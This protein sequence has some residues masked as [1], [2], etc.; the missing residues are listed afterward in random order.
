MGHGF[1]PVII[2]H[3]SRGEARR[4][5]TPTILVGRCADT[6]MARCEGAM[7]GAAAGSAN[8]TWSVAGLTTVVEGT[9]N[10]EAELRDWMEAH[11]I[12]TSGYGQGKAK[13]IKD[14]LKELD[15]R[16]RRT[17]RHLLSPAPIAVPVRVALVSRR[18]RR[19]LC[20][21]STERST[22]ASQS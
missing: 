13:R 8:G 14:L 2:K 1:S 4:S 21:S 16:V 3:P 17:Q 9:F 10:E 18:P 11:G 20:S 19:A 7:P 15:R 6:R 5:R 12:D 22:A